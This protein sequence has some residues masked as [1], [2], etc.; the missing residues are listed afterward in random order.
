MVRGVARVND[1]DFVR[2]VVGLL[3]GA[4]VRAWVFGGWAAE[5]L[6]LSAP[7]GHR[8]VD[9][10]YPADGF[11]VVDGF[12]ARGDVHEIVAKRFPHKRAFEVDGIM[13]ELFL[14][15]ADEAGAF[16]D[17]WGVA[18]HDWPADVFDIE[19]HGLRVASTTAVTGY[20]EAWEELQAKRQSR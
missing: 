5:L 4:R 11:E 14:V 18:R 6:E 15:Q 10:L 13:V 1:L 3:E 2:Y 16:T 9:L 19:A 8:D 20:R 12:L 7:R 17:F